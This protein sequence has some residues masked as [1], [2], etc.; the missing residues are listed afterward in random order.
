ML[1]LLH[2]QT[3]TQENEMTY[4]ELLTQKDLKE[5]GY[6]LRELQEMAREDWAGFRADVTIETGERMPRIATRRQTSPFGWKN[7]KLIYSI[8]EDG[9]A[10]DIQIGFI[11]SEKYEIETIYLHHLDD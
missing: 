6:G 5:I 8:I 1:L 10:G 9:D 7:E 11:P 4:G 3:D 2:N